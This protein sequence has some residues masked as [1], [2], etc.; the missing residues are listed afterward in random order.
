VDFIY[1]GIS[2]PGYLY[3]IQIP[4]RLFIAYILQIIT[5]A[6]VSPPRINR[7]LSS[8]W[9]SYRNVSFDIAFTSTTSGIG[10]CELHEIAPRRETLEDIFTS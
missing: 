2:R 8:L 4:E 10:A 7:Q 6:R 9:R 5:R 1:R 3:L